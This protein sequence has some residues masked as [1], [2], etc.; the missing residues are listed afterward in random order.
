MKAYKEL[1]MEHYYALLLRPVDKR[2]AMK[3]HFLLKAYFNH[4]N[5][6]EIIKLH[7]IETQTVLISYKNRKIGRTYCC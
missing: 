2:R 3:L 7:D 4:I 6:T 1:G 5:P